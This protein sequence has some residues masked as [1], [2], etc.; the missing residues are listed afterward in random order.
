MNKLISEMTGQ[1][2]D[3]VE[4]DADRDFFMDAKEA[5]KYGII[6]EIYEPRSAK[7]RSNACPIR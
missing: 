5:L 6:D 1:P 3:N 2:L 7:R 4:K